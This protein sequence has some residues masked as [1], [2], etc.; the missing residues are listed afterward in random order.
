MNKLSFF[1]K[2][3]LALLA[4]G[5]ATNALAQG[6]IEPLAGTWKTWILRSGSEFRL[7]PPPGR[8][9][10]LLPGPAVEDRVPGL[11]RVERPRPG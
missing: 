9:M 10:G 1:G 11:A 5:L 3:A 7:P 4:G 2:T 6:Q 8:D